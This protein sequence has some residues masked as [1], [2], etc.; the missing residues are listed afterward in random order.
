M[1]S[2]VL[3]HVQLTV[4]LMHFVNLFII[5]ASSNKVVVKFVPMCDLGEKRTGKGGNGT[6]INSICYQGDNVDDCPD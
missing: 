1:T 5:H 2:L 6:K 4:F 3:N